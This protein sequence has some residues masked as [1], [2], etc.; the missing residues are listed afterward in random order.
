MEPFWSHGFFF[1]KHSGKDTLI[2][3]NVLDANFLIARD[4][5]RVV[6]AVALPSP[7]RTPGAGSEQSTHA[8]FTIRASRTSMRCRARAAGAL[9]NHHPGQ[10]GVSKWE[11]SYEGR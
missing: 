7:Q 2:A 4:L 9:G 6:N 8:I 11:M 3:Q 10:T 5:H 1:N